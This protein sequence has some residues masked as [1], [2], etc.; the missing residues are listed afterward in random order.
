MRIEGTAD[1]TFDF[2]GQLFV[3]DD[4]FGVPVVEKDYI[5]ILYILIIIIILIIVRSLFFLCSFSVLCSA[6]RTCQNLDI[7]RSLLL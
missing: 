6:Y 7:V 2:V 1:F 3:D 4:F 5:Y